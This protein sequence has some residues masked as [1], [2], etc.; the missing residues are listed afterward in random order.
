MIPPNPIPPRQP[1][2]GP[3]PSAQAPVVGSGAT[4]RPPIPAAQ[5]PAGLPGAIR[6]GAA[7]AVAPAGGVNAGELGTPWQKQFPG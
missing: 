5:G 7:P 3:V 6:P 2:M 1:V 4:P